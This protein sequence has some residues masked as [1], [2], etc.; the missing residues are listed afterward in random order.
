[1]IPQSD[2][3]SRLHQPLPPVSKLVVNDEFRIPLCQGSGH[4]EAERIIILPLNPDIKQLISNKNSR[5]ADTL[6]RVQVIE[7]ISGRFPRCVF[8]EG[9]FTVIFQKIFYI[10]LLWLDFYLT[11]IKLYFSRSVFSGALQIIPCSSWLPQAGQNLAAS[12]KQ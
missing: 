8:W 11:W 7:Y 12:L 4:C 2:K 1:M 10:F 6:S 9:I 5:S 3:K